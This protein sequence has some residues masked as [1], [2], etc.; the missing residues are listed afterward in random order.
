M[1]NF[2]QRLLGTR[3]VMPSAKPYVEMG[4]SGTPNFSGFLTTPEKS[5]KWT[6]KQRYITSSN[7]ATNVS[8]VAAGI[9]YF[10]NLVARP[11]WTV[12][13][14]N[15]TPEA[16]HAAEFV[17]SVITS[18]DT[19][20]S[21]VVRR[22][23]MYK[24]HGFSIMEWTAI[25][26]EDGLIGLKDIE[27]RPQHTIEQWDLN[28]DGSVNG[29]F[30]R[31]PQ[32]AALLPLP[33]AKLVYMV[34][35]TLT[36][37]PEGLGVFRHLAE[38][39]ERLNTYLILEARAFE[40]DL[41]GIPIGRIPYTLINN[42][43]EA[44]KLSP[45]KA[46]AL[47]KSMEDFVKISVKQSDTGLTLDSMPYQSTTQDGP[48]IA[49]AMQWDLDLLQGS[50]NGL[51]EIAAAIDR[52]QREMARIIGTEILMMGDQGGNRALAMDKSRNLYLIANSVL[53]YISD[54]FTKDVVDPLWVLN[55]L[56]D[57]IKPTLST[58]DVAFKD[59]ME[60]S[61]VL[62]DMA[63]AGAVLPQNDPVITDVRELMGVSPPDPLSA[64]LLGPLDDPPMSD[65][66]IAA[67]E[68]R[69]QALR[70]ANGEDAN[71]AV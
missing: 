16:V 15:D 35:D 27:T 3:L 11:K 2:I 51:V 49:N 56:S 36:D 4:V 41:R 21:R 33:R 5:A 71:A 7:I 9:H 44:G 67:E 37:S 61:T 29:V 60:I 69:Q 23:V 31:S 50:A 53:S 10:V 68:A 48:K 47:V 26:R 19:P 30:Q 70:L 25:K 66:E 42:A 62:K 17:E 13:P 58:E 64:E 63:T 59:V 46:A 18:M 28:E 65:E 40:R 43:V 38:P 45:D 55:G 39:Y 22:A 54:S 12:S 14:A 34:D 52:L 1:P 32:T 20:W 6:G 24:F 8:I 57:D